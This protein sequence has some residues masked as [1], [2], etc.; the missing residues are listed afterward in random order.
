MG[1]NSSINFTDICEINIRA[2]SHVFLDERWHYKSSCHPFSRLYYV[3]DGEGFLKTADREIKMQGGY[4]YFIPAECEI[5]YGCTTLEKIFF[6]ISV[7]TLDNYDLFSNVKEIYAL[8]FEEGLYQSLLK[9]CKPESYQDVLKL[10]MLLLSTIMEFQKVYNFEERP[11]KQY[12]DVVKDTFEYIHKNLKINLKAA[13]IAEYLFVSESKLRNI[14]KKEMN[15]PI[16]QYIE[17]M[18]FIK[19]KNL[20]GDKHHSIDEI[21]AQLGFY[22]RFH[23]SRRFKE[24]FNQSPGEF[25]KRSAFIL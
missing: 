10:K 21:S 20:L 17:D 15:M 22:D 25:N 4:A 5:D 24:K 3:K 19:A 16:G 18:V 12:S 23:F 6:H 9:C 1:T 7:R 13:E 2:A 11:I 8:P 14:F